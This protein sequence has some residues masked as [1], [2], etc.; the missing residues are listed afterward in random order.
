[1]LFDLEDRLDARL[2]VLE[3]EDDVV[4]YKGQ[5]FT[6]TGMDEKGNRY[7]VNKGNTVGQVN[8]DLSIELWGQ[9]EEESERKTTK[10]SIPKVTGWELTWDDIATGKRTG[11][12]YPLGFPQSNLDKLVR[13]YAQKGLGPVLKQARGKSKYLAVG[14]P[15]GTE[16]VQKK[17][18]KEGGLPPGELKLTQDQLTKLA[19]MLGVSAQELMTAGGKQITIVDEPVTAKVDE[20]IAAKI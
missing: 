13:L 19:K 8:P 5:L 18:K 7:L 2:A 6:M 1:M 11:R 20:P 16:V 9:G 17:M 10:P 14:I 4:R 15:P 12:F 3:G